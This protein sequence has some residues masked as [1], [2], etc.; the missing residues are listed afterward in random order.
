[1]KR[2]IPVPIDRTISDGRFVVVSH[3]ELN[4]FWDEVQDKFKNM[5]PNHKKDESDMNKEGEGKEYNKDEA[6]DALKEELRDLHE[7]VGKLRELVSDLY[8]FMQ[9]IGPRQ[10]N[11]RSQMRRLP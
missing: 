3:G 9:A 1:M 6:R 2:V 4:G 7:T 5:W 11:S 10:D 8:Q